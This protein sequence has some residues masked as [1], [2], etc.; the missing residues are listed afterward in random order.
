[1]RTMGRKP[2]DKKMRRLSVQ[3]KYKKPVSHEQTSDS[4]VPQK[5]KRRTQSYTATSYRSFRKKATTP[6]SSAS[7]TSNRVADKSD[8]SS[9]YEDRFDNAK[10]GTPNTAVPVLDANVPSTSTGITANGKG[11]MF[12]ISNF[13]NDSD[14]SIP[15]SPH[16]NPDSN[17]LI[18]TLTSPPLHN[19]SNNHRS[20]CHKSLSMTK[21]TFTFSFGKMIFLMVCVLMALEQA[22]N[23]PACWVQHSVKKIVKLHIRMVVINKNSKKKIH[24]WKTMPP[25]TLTRWCLA[26]TTTE[27]TQTFTRSAV[28][29]KKMIKILKRMRQKLQSLAQ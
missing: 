28:E 3:T 8:S 2:Y 15:D 14:E 17:R 21:L 25:Q 20:K 22:L 18:R 13:A 23:V 1:M 5:K 11:F 16:P 12:R 29:L 27:V 24:L 26:R 19:I 10:N 4:E 6:L 7:N 9:D